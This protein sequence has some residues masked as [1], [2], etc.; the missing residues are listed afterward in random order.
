MVIGYDSPMFDS[1]NYR[2]TT[3][4]FEKMQKETSFD[5]L[6]QRYPN[7]FCHLVGFSTEGEFEL[8]QP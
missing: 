2:N 7:T 5:Y 8:M 4:E 1:D 3:A 6:L